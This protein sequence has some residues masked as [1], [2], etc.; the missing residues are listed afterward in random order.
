[1]YFR[2]AEC[3][4][5]L[6]DALSEVGAEL[7]SFAYA[8]GDHDCRVGNDGSPGI[9]TF[10]FGNVGGSPIFGDLKSCESDELNVKISVTTDLD[11]YANSWSLVSS[12]R[13]YWESES[14]LDNLTTY[15][16]YLCLDASKCYTFTMYDLFDDGL[17]NP[18]TFSLLVDGELLLEDGDDYFSSV[19]RLFGE[20]D[21]GSASLNPSPSIVLVP[22]PTL[23]LDPFVPLSAPSSRPSIWRSAF[24]SSEP[25]PILSLNVISPKESVAMNNGTIRGIHAWFTV[26]FVFM[27]LFY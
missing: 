3:K 18:G 15:N 13:D 27:F 19:R 2:A 16:S 25:S 21:F 20:C 9:Y 14:F 7:A 5:A 23:L 24:R 1:M 22:S 11:D 4:L 8:P 26:G 12:T 10:A 17:D 6:N